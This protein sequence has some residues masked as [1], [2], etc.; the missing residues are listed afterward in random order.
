MEECRADL[1]TVL[2]LRPEQVEAA[3][4]TAT[5]WTVRV[6][7]PR[8]AMLGAHV[9]GA[10]RAAGA[11]PAVH[12][13][14]G[15]PLKQVFAQEGEAPGRGFGIA[16]GGSRRAFDPARP[17]RRGVQ[18]P[19]QPRALVRD[20]LRAEDAASASREA[21]PATAPPRG[22]QT[23][24]ARTAPPCAPGW[25]RGMQAILPGRNARAWGP[26]TRYRAPAPER[27][28]RCRRSSHSSE[29]PGGRPAKRAVESGSP[30]PCAVQKRARFPGQPTAA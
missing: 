27:G 12:S 16:R 20:S 15:R 30:A 10:Q 23:R 25:L 22:P 11:K 6:P 17:R 1:A 3:A 9:G 8:P 24:S 21:H 29:A 14:T 28:W 5:R 19:A 7:S 2:G 18:V 13:R 4:E 26:A